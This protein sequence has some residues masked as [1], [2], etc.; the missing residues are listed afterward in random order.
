MY[1]HESVRTR[2]G[3]S[4]VPSTSPSERDW[5][6]LR[7]EARKL[8]SEVDVKLAGFSK[9]GQGFGDASPYSS[10]GGVSKSK[11]GDQ[12][13]GQKAAELEAL[14]QR[15][16]DINDSMSSALSGSGVSRM[17]TVARHR[18]ILLEFTQEFRRTRSVITAGL[19]KATLLGG[20]VS[21]SASPHIGVD[22]QSGNGSA[23]SLLR[24]R[25]AIHSSNMNIDSVISQAQAAMSVMSSQRGL[26]DGM[27]SKITNLGTRF[28]VVN[29]M[30]TA[31]RKKRSRDTMILALVFAACFLFTLMYWLNK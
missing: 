3:P 21:S 13:V 11:S 17:H 31:I 12:L 24:E 29:S 27:D 7:R 4:G 26:F 30:L 5:E 25:N 23:A 1:T 18:D 15:L 10:A 19:E 14:L 2:G 16:S 22:I 8:E 28:P 20:R 6:E 9:L